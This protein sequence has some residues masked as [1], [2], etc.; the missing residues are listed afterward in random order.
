[1]FRGVIPFL[2]ADL[3][4]LFSLILFPAMVLWLPTVLGT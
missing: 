3:V 1:V 4:H 2:L